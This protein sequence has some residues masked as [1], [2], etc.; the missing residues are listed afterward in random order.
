MQPADQQGRRPTSHPARQSAD[1][2][3]EPVAIMHGTGA[4]NVANQCTQISCDNCDQEPSL[5]P[6]SVLPSLPR[7]PLR[8]RK[9]LHAQANQADLGSCLQRLPRGGIA[10]PGKAIH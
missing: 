5:L 1:Q 9:P 8:F 6:S 4:Y 10:N 7:L 3:L 2:A